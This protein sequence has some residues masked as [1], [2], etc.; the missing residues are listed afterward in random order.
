MAEHILP[1]TIWH[2]K[3]RLAET[4]ARAAFTAGCV[5]LTSTAAPA[6]AVTRIETVPAPSLAANLLGDPAWRQVTVYLPPSYPREPRRRYPVVYWLHG[7]ASA[8]RELISGIRQGLNIRLAMDSLLAAGA[9]R[10]MIIVM[11]NARNAFEGSFY[12]NSPVTGRWEDFIVRDLVSWVDGRY[13]TVWSRSGRGIAG[14][15]MGGFGAL[16]IAIRNPDTYSAVYAMSPCCLDSEVFFERSWLAAWRGAA[17]VKTLED[18]ARAPFRSQLVIARSAFYSPDTA[19]PP[20]YVAFPVIPDGDSLRLVPG[21]A[22]L[23]RNDPLALIPRSAPALR[24]LAIALD[25][26]AQDG[27]PDIP[28][29]VRAVDS[30]L[31]AM[32]IAHEAEIYQGG[33]VDK[34]RERIVTR[35]LP[36]FSRALSGAR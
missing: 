16:R 9:A 32:G 36:F 23:W 17:A 28:A 19:R 24:R 31:T 18:F 4:L 5:L 13:R 15:S 11:P 34:V 6:Q 26:G 25:A 10:E 8:D 27:F 1:K 2:G 30:L 22:A 3:P 14:S 21:I 20:L 33:H 29:N 35:V 12:A 7:F